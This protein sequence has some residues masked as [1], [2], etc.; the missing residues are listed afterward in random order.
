MLLAVVLAV[1]PLLVRL[2]LL[3]L[4]PLLLHVL[5]FL[6]FASHRLWRCAPPGGQ[7]RGDRCCHGQLERGPDATSSGIWLELQRDQQGR[8]E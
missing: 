6:L 5:R 8:A 7:G 3:L 4:L 1:L 2:L